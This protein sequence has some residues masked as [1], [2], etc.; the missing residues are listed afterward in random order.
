MLLQVTHDTHYRYHPAVE[1]AQ[2]VAYLHPCNHPGQTLLDHQL[3]VN[4]QPAQMRSM[5]DVYG[6]VRCFFSLQTPHEVLSVVAHSLVSTQ[7]SPEVHSSMGW[8]KVREQF[9]YQASGQYDAAAEFVFAS[10]YVPR[11]TEFG[12]YARPDFAAG[13]SL[14]EAT[15]RL[16]ERIH[17]EFTYASQSTQINTPALEALAQRKGVCQD[18]S[19]IMIACLRTLGLPARYVSGYL[20]TTPVPGEVKLIGSDA[21]H[22]WVSVYLPD[23]PPGQRWVDFDPTN[24]R[25]GW[26]APGPDYVTVATGRDFGDVSPLRGVIHGGASHLLTV[27]VTVQSVGENTNQSSSQSQSQQQS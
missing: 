6:N 16:M 10:P 19:H 20:L 21:S 8:E 7:A 13:T 11:H 22:A 12:A 15:V 24:N 4:P 17:T 3:S 26:H 23:L 14:L 18:F 25:W 27:G 1:T 9:R 2:H 5:P